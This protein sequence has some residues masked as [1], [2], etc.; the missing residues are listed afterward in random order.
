MF[1]LVKSLVLKAMNVPSEPEPP[2]GSEGSLKVFRASKN[3]F[4]CRA[5]G[6]A[7]GQCIFLGILGSFLLGGLLALWEELD[8]PALVVFVLAGAALVVG[9]IH[10]IFSFSVLR[11]D[12]EMRWYMVTDRSLRIRDGV[13]SVRE[14]TMT[15]ANIQNISVSQG[16]IQRLFK[17][18]D[19]QVRTAGGGGV[20]Q[21]GAQH[22][23]HIG[24]FGG[25]D[26][27]E[28][29]RDLILMRLKKYKDAG[30]G[31]PDDAIASARGE[32]SGLSKELRGA[33]EEARG[34]REAAQRLLVSRG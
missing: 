10:L 14:M 1:D 20:P 25:V 30:L 28:E 24:R 13:W 7:I 19:L 15:F 5:V 11:L 18:A 4:Y 2:G 21:E 12:Y 32:A 8:L 34:L 9:V 6:W 17:I 22:A 26:N 33:V 29:I 3:Y 16:P 27:A 31:E 23:M